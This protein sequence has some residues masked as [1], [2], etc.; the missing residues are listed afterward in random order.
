MQWVTR[1]LLLERSKS[2]EIES[3]ITGFVDGEGSFLISFSRRPTMLSG[4]EV[5]PSFTV[6]QHERSKEVL[7]LLQEYFN[8]VTVRDNKRDSTWKYEVRSLEDLVTKIIPHFMEYPLQTSK[9]KD[10]EAFTTICLNMKEKQ[11]L[12]VN[13]LEQIIRSAYVMNND[14]A[15][16]YL[17]TDLLKI[18]SKMNV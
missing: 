12:Q 17:Q 5:R 15:R 10:F 13:G 14:G 7:I 9:Q 18:V 16:R 1:R 6:S 4:I 8:C 2:M 11:H 3:Y